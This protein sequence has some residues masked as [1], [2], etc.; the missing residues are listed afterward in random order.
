VSLNMNSDVFFFYHYCVGLKKMRLLFNFSGC[1][2]GVR[3]LLGAV[4]HPATDVDIRQG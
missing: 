2:R 3:H 4:S 1:G